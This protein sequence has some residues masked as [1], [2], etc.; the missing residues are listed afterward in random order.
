MW[1]YKYCDRRFNKTHVNKCFNRFR[2]IPLDEWNLNLQ[3]TNLLKFS[4]SVLKD[5]V[6]AKKSDCS[7]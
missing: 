4:Q 6:V 7:D 2:M 1:S 3:M 5:N